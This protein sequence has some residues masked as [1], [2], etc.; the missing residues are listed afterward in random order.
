MEFF[1]MLEGQNPQDR[2]AY[3]SDETPQEDETSFRLL[4]YYA[5]S[6]R[7]QKYNGMDVVRVSVAD[8][9]RRSAQLD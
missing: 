8:A 7:H 5:E 1:A 6:V 9:T 4:R 2:L 3:L